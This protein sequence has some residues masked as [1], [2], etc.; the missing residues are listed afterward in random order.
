MAATK[1]VM[2]LVIMVIIMS[3]H[4]PIHAYTYARGYRKHDNTSA[5]VLIDVSR[6]FHTRAIKIC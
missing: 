5:L 1:L 2:M 4:Y 6:R 3:M